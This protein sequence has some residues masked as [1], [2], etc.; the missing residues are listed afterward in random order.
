MT[1]TPNDKP[2]I[3]VVHDPKNDCTYV[4]D[5][6]HGALVL[7]NLDDGFVNSFGATLRNNPGAHESMISRE[8]LLN[9]VSLQIVSLETSIR[10]LK[11]IKKKYSAQKKYRA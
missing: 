9:H 2:S 3:R 6:I 5:T 11:A 1:N 4:V 8:A 7:R 10:E